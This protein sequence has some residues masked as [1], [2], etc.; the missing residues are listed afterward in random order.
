MKILVITSLFP[1]KFNPDYGR[2]SAEL[3]QSL[4]SRNE[5]TVI[6]PISLTPPMYI[7]RKSISKPGIIKNWIRE[8][9]KIPKQELFKNIP[10]YYPQ[11]FYLPKK[12]SKMSLGVFLFLRLLPIVHELR[13]RHGFEIIHAFGEFPEGFAAFLFSKIYRMPVIISHRRTFTS[14]QLSESYLLKKIKNYIINKVDVNIISSNALY[15]HQNKMNSQNYQLIPPGI[16][17]I[18]FHPADKIKIRENLEISPAKH[19]LLFRGNL[20]PNSGINYLIDA[21][22]LLAS[23]KTDLILYIIGQGIL[24][25]ALKRKIR[26][27]NL[28]NRIFIKDHVADHEIP[29]WMNAADLFIAP[30]F[31]MDFPISAIEALS[32]GTPVI[33]CKTDVTEELIS[34][35]KHGLLTNPRDCQDLAK[36]I[37]TG[38]TINWNR[39]L[40]VSYAKK[41]DIKNTVFKIQQIYER[42]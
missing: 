38:F 24:K 30:N 11:L 12:I 33:A 26:K 5:F 39:E 1:N 40:L 36:N 20:L 37:S 14:G 16:D 15:L 8:I 28:E 18:K 2:Y 21:F 34:D 32:C 7:A 25:D 27:L 19:V 22:E 42:V 41:Y 13:K 35:Q 17:L 3:L 6:C 10:I 23:K 9:R 4:T 31:T 29:V